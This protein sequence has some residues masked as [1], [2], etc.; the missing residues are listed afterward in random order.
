MIRPWISIPVEN[1]RV[2][3]DHYI[4]DIRIQFKD[5]ET[6]DTVI[7]QLEEIRPIVKEM[8]EHV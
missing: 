4:G 1:A 2:T 5:I 7:A 8:E 3:V 6:I